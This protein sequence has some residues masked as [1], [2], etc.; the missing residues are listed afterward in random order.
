MLS[1]YKSDLKGIDPAQNT[2]KIETAYDPVDDMYKIKSMQKKW[3]DSFNGSSLDSTNWE[4]SVG[5][6]GS[7]AVSAGVLT[8]GSGTTVNAQ[9]SIISKETF[10]VPFKLSFG[11]TMSQRIINQTLYIEAISVDKVTGMPDGLHSTA[12]FFDGTIATQGKYRVQNGGLT[13]LDSALS[14]LPTT[15]SGSF[16]EIEPFADEV[17][18]HGGTLDST[19]GRS[20]S[21]RRHQQIP[22][23]N[24]VYKIRL[25]WLNGSVAPVSNTNAIFQ[26]IACSDYAELT[27]EITSGRGQSVAGQAIGVNIVSSLP[28]GAANIGIVT[29]LTPTPYTLTSAASTNA[30]SVKAT[31]GTLFTITYDNVNVA[32]RYLK[33]YNKATAP[34]VGTDVPILTIPLPAT[35][36]NVFNLGAL[37]H[38]FSTGIAFAI[39]GAMAY[40]DLTVIA[41]GDVH[42]SLSYV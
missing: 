28:T 25:R 22:D 11:F 20:N 34:A 14:T 7:V 17:W 29:P 19:N 41:A 24:A 35:S 37:G 36:G 6:G 23:P 2:V 31:A 9:T 15:A 4:L 12:L 3:R 10:T 32:A 33:L 39:T 1:N 5:T 21:Y 27:A 30:T 26:Y 38:R 18:F 8:I 42:L 13:P 16:F 40:T